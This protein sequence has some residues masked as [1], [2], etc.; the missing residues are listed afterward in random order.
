MIQ[1]NHH[2]ISLYRTTFS[3]GWK[4]QHQQWTNSWGRLKVNALVTIMLVKDKSRKLPFKIQK[5]N[6]RIIRDTNVQI[7]YSD[8]SGGSLHSSGGNGEKKTKIKF[9]QL[10]KL[11]T[12]I[13]N[14]CR[15]TRIRSLRYSRATLAPDR[16]D[17]RYFGSSRKSDLLLCLLW[18][19]VT[20][21]EQYRV[22]CRQ[23]CSFKSIHIGDNNSDIPG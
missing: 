15:W 6:E 12:S 9:W 8:F 20:W 10:T 3:P 22:Q 2:I 11:K 17:I 5:A 13:P 7:F 21:T 1:F 14:Y 23:F 4:D 18:V 16:D 19:T